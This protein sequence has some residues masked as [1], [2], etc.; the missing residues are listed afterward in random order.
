M[1]YADP[2]IGDPAVGSGRPLSGGRSADAERWISALP[3]VAVSP[4]RQPD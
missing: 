2:I 4:Q 3:Q 1:G